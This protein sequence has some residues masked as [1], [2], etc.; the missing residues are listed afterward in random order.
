MR[1]NINYSN[2]DDASHHEQANKSE[3]SSKTMIRGEPAAVIMKMIM[4]NPH[5]KLMNQGRQ[6]P[7][8]PRRILSSMIPNNEAIA[9]AQHQ[10]Q[11]PKHY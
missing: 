1:P 2:L 9:K 4:K 5:G 6:R 10:L 3:R 8:R 11:N 7:R